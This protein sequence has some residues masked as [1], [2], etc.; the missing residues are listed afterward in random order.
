MDERARVRPAAR[1][2]RRGVNGSHPMRAIRVHR[3][4]GPEELTL[5]QVAHPRPGPGQASVR[6]AFAG[7]N[8]IDVYHR[9]GLYPMALPLTLGSEAAGVVDAVGEGVAEVRV[10]DRV[11]YAM[12]VGSYAEHA[13]VEA[14]KLVPVP[15]EVPFEQAAAVMLQGLTAHYLSHSAFP[16]GAGHVA[17]VHAAAGGVGLL[18]IQVAK[19]LGARVI[20]TVSTPEKAELARAAGADEV[21]LYTK[22]NFKDAARAFTDDK[23]VDVVYDSVGRT[24]FMDSLDALKRRGTMVLFGQS[25]GFAPPLDLGLLQSKGS[26]FVTRPTLA[27]Y[28]ADRA[29][30][31]GRAAD[32]FGWIGTGELSIRIDRIVPLANAAEAHRLLEGRATA[33]KVLL[34]C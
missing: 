34:A 25:S 6:V 11:A 13:L 23:G 24:T 19:R 10:G 20:G 31:L 1:A 5:E 3:T 16:L 22:A 30:L 14:W 28:M 29:E 32:L 12:Q 17:L 9:S 2:A 4:G 27:H 26:L 33:G 18:L 21:V 7:V 15:A 8:F